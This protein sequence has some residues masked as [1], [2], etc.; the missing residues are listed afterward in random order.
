MLI[1]FF[2]LKSRGISD[3]DARQLL[4]EA[5]LVDVIDELGDPQR[6]WLMAAIKEWI[7]GR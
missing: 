7:E 2:Y 5:F 3:E 1:S 4:I 6:D